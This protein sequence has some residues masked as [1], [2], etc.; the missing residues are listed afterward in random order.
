MRY[1]QFDASALL[2]LLAQCARQMQQRLA[3]PLL[4]VHRHHIGDHLL[5]V[6]NARGQVS[7]KRLN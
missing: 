7:D 1:L 3:Q 5:L 6:G 2:V 4:A